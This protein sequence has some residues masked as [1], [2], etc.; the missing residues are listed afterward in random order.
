MSCTCVCLDCIAG[1]HCGGNEGPCAEPPE[2][3]WSEEFNEEFYGDDLEL[4]E[5]LDWRESEEE[6]RRCG[7]PYCYCGNL[8]T[9]GE[10]CSECLSGAHQG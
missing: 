10:T 4:S 2:G 3:T 6:N 8:T 5:Y 1:R 7:C 9:A